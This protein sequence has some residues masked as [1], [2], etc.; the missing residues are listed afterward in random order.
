VRPFLHLVSIVLVLPVFVLALA[1][2]VL[3]H[4]ISAGSLWGFF[5]QLLAD[6]VWLVPWGILA[7]GAGWLVV[8]IGGMFAGTRW[9]AGLFVAVVGVG[10]TALAVVLTIGHSNAD[11]GQLPFYVPGLVAA[12]IGAWLALTER[13]RHP[14]VA[15]RI[16]ASD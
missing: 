10:S 13:P 6:A 4:A 5:D 12:S 9:L 14:A 11:A 3:G 16:A 1:F 15:P 7:I 2:A 8:A